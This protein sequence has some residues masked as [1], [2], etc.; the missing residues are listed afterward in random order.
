MG[1]LP[2]FDP[3]PIFLVRIY[4]SLNS[5]S[6]HQVGLHLNAY[7]PDHILLKVSISRPLQHSA[8]QKNNHGR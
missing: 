7:S 8:Y 5:D 3:P 1:F 6:L 2:L 4:N